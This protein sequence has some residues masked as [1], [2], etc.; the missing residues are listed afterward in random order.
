[1]LP[2]AGYAFRI[3]DRGTVRG[4]SLFDP[5]ILRFRFYARLVRFHP[6]SR[7]IYRALPKE[8]APVRISMRLI[9]SDQR[10]AV[11]VSYA[12][13]LNS[14]RRIQL[15]KIKI[16]GA[17]IILSVTVALPACAQEAGSTHLRRAHN[18]LS[19]PFQVTPR[20][21]PTSTIDSVGRSE[22][23]PSRV[24]GENADLHPASS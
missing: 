11:S 10:E 13:S 22:R 15:T 9:E 3:C 4:N 1:V 5:M 12:S 2:A 7:E 21:R 18:E 8:N 14:K 24:G 16:Q 17:A 19:E 23:D 6:M 20:A